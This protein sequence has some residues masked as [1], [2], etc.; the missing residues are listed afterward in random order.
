MES[1][2]PALLDKAKMSFCQSRS[3]MTGFMME[4]HKI[5]EQLLL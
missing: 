4:A 5:N 2:N 3:C 1:A